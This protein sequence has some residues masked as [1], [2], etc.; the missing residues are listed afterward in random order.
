M[1]PCAAFFLALFWGAEIA[2]RI[3]RILY[4]QSALL[5]IQLVYDFVG[6][7]LYYFLYSGSAQ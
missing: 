2:L 6:L 3:H 7:L 4:M 1:Q 5:P